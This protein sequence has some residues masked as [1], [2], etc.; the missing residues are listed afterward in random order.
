[1]KLDSLKKLYVHELKDLYSAEHQILDG[2]GAMIA[3]TTDEQLK[4]A[5]QEHRKET[6]GQIKRLDTIFSSL[7]FSPG[8]ERCAAMA[9]LIKEAS[10]LMEMESE[11]EVLDAALIA[12]AQRIEHYE[13]AGYGTARAYAEKLGDYQAADLLQATL[14]EEGHAD[15]LLTRIAERSL[16][17]VAMQT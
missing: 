5:F 2:L 7:E 16:N 15:H 9:G 17:Y 14:D 4:R 3:A 11:P 13:M 1:M 10:D 12:A 6:Q 8:G